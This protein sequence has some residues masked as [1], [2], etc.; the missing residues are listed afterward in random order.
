MT[1]I[2]KGLMDERIFEVNVFPICSLQSCQ[3]V[4]IN[5]ITS[6][7]KVCVAPAEQQDIF[8]ARHIFWCYTNNNHVYL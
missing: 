1:S 5:M 3:S 7:L 2:S 4:E 8:T 6:H